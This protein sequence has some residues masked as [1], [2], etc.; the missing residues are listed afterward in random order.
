MTPSSPTASATSTA[1]GATRDPFIKRYIWGLSFVVGLLA[2]T[3]LKTCQSK[4]LPSLQ[5]ISVVEPFELIDQNGQPFGSKQ[6]DGKVWIASFFFTACKTECPL[7]GRAVK[8]LQDKLA[9]TPV[10]LVSISVDPEF[11]DPQ[12]LRNWGAQFGADP[13]RWHLL[14][15]PRPAVEAVVGVTNKGL[16]TYMGESRK[17][18]GG[19]VTI[20]HEMKVVLVDQHRGIR[21][22][23]DTRNEGEMALLVDHAKA[24]A[25]EGAAR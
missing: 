23:F 1:S 14:T 5:V 3:I 19:L 18:T 6:L 25:R 13:A 15:G 9:D 20:A 7:I 17:V 21:F 11:D 22:Y 24:L 4:S 10:Q 8:D 16:K 2:L 12:A